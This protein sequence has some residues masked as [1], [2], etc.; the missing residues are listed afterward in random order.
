MKHHSSELFKPL[1]SLHRIFN[2]ALALMRQAQEAAKEGKDSLVL[3][4]AA[5]DDFAKLA[6]HEKAH[7]IMKGAAAYNCYLLADDALP[8]DVEKDHLKHQAAKRAWLEM[9]AKCHSRSAQDELASLKETET[10]YNPE[11][12]EQRGSASKMVLFEKSESPA[13]K[14]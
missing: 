6:H 8:W 13:P 1:S 4:R 3:Y 11:R 10:A 14:G 5:F 2:N 9:A 7:V 12:T